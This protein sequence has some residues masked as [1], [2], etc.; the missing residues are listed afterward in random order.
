[1]KYFDDKCS[2]QREKNWTKTKLKTQCIMADATKKPIN[3]S[4][5]HYE[6]NIV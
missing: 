6:Y 4:F 3:A 2:P 5:K 1:L